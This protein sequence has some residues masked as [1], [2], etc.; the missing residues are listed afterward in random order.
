MTGAV[1]DTLK[2]VG[3]GDELDL[4]RVVETSFEVDFGKRLEWTTV[5][6]MFLA[7][8]A[9][10]PPSDEVGSCATS[11][12]F[13]QLRRASPFL[14]EIDVKPDTRLR[15][16]GIR[17]PKHFVRVLEKAS[18]LRL[19]PANWAITAQGGCLLALTG[20]AGIIL[21]GLLDGSLAYLGYLT[22]VLGFML[23]R[24]DRGSF[25]DKSFGELARETAS[26]NVARLIDQG[27]DRRESALWRALTQLIATETGVERSHIARATRLFA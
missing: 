26:L 2:L 23:I 18:G 1:A 20:L 10:R 3:D 17:H 22:V 7:L 8:K 19:P 21:S 15:N 14:T 13:Y 5:E 16:L 9:L 24:F 12:T 27:A 25:D 11:M 4:L 6:H